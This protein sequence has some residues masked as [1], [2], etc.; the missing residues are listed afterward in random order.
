MQ[1]KH[2]PVALEHRPQ[3]PT[4]NQL[5]LCFILFIL[6]VLFCFGATP[7]NAQ[8]LLLTLRS[9]IT[10]PGGVWGP[11]AWDRIQ[12]SQLHGHCPTAVLQIL[13]SSLTSDFKR[14]KKR[15]MGVGGEAEKT[16]VFHYHVRH[17]QWPSG[18]ILRPRELRLVVTIRN[19]DSTRVS[20][21]PSLCFGPLFLGLYFVTDF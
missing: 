15:L 1:G 21:I 11:D 4:F 18:S 7:A 9:G 3:G 2:P 14:R 10:L 8:G 13:S 17:S 20:C 19:R 5:S 12:A 16:K 6:F